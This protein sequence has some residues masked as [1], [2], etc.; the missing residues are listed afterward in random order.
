VI[1][2][3]VGGAE[4]S[5]I[6]KQQQTRLIGT[7]VVRRRSWRTHYT[8]P[9]NKS[10]DSETAVGVELDI[11]KEGGPSSHSIPLRCSSPL[12]FSRR[13]SSNGDSHKKGAVENIPSSAPSSAREALIRRKSS[14][15][16]NDKKSKPP[17]QTRRSTQI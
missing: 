10:L 7:G 12:V 6:S 4:L 17:V 9:K 3:V 2:V 11:R 15:N 14:S 13:H 16:N 5:D 8:R 1:G